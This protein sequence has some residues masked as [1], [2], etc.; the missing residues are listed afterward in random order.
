MKVGIVGAG[1]VGTA[2]MF[3]MAL[4][5]SAREIVLVNRNYG[6]AKGA[7]TD[8]QY[9]T[10]LGP[11][12]SL[13]AG[14]YADLRGAAIVV[15]TAG[16]NEKSGGATDRNDPAGR[17]RLLDTNVGIYRDMVPRIAAAAPD[18][19]LLAVTDPPDPLAELARSLAG[20]GRVLS[21][22][23]LLDSL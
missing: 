6:R 10:V 7:V 21:T 1:A 14:E 17:L 8:L 16:A 15:I 20:H 2:C 18:A 23:T 11:T 22:G 4:R 5:G 12:V 9:G 19:V 3:A 13:R